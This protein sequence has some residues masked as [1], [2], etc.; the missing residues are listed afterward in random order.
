LLRWPAPRPGA[1]LVGALSLVVAAAGVAELRADRRA[2]RAAVALRDGRTLDAIDQS[3]LALQD[4]PDLVRYRLVAAQA[5]ASAGR[6]DAALDQLDLAARYSPRDPAVRLAR[7]QILGT[8]D[9]WQDVV[10]HDP[11]NGSAWMQL[12]TVLADTG[13]A[14]TAEQA[15][16][17]AQ[18]LA[19][20]NVLPTLG[21]ARLYLDE[22]RLDQAARA[23]E[24]A[25]TTAPGD[26]RID[27]LAAQLDA[28]D[29]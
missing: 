22:R 21:L 8:A 7:A 29:G 12:G 26:P 3:R 13:K 2:H 18:T 11:R 9:A 17:R 1:V 14:A 6:Q 20:Y 19:P 5:L 16:L 27:D 15:W 28:V 10:G 24:R 4:R 23:L 25:R